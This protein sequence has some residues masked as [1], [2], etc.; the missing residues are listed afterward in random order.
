[1]L[2]RP[3]RATYRVGETMNLEILTSDSAGNIYLDI[4]REGQTLSTRALP[5]TDGKATAAVDLTPDLYGTLT[6]HAYKLLPY[7]D[8]VRDTRLVVVDS[9]NDLALDIQL[10]RDTYL[11]GEQASLQIDVSGQDGQGTNRPW[12]WPWWTNRSLPC[13]SRIPDLPSSTFC[14]KRSSW[15][16]SLT[17]TVCPFPP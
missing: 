12:A 1:M 3:E 17:S 11:P 13:R 15:N 7:G 6:L 4:T 2:L 9:A 16:P 8:I 5:I 10:D 14:W